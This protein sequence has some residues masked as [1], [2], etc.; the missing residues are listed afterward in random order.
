MIH[1]HDPE[2]ER[3]ATKDGSVGYLA[4]ACSILR[5]RIQRWLHK[6]VGEPLTTRK[7]SLVAVSCSSAS[8]N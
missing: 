7:I 8:M 4:E 2:P 6:S 3:E 1:V 5:D